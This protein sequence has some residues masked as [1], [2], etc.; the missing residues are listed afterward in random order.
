MKHDH[1]FP[2]PYAFPLLAFFFVAAGSAFSQTT[3][4]IGDLT[5]TG[6][7]KS[8]TS[9]S[10]GGTEL[11][12]GGMVISKGTYS[13]AP[14]LASSDQ[15]AGTRMLWYPGKAAFRVGAVSG[16][17]W[18][19]VN[20]GTY[21]TAFG[22]AST[23]SGS[24]S[25]SAGMYPQASG[26]ASIAMGY[27]PVAT[28][29]YSTAIGFSTHASG[30]GSTAFGYGAIASGPNSTAMGV[31]TVASGDCSTAMGGFSIASGEQATAMGC[32]SIASGLYS[33]SMGICTSA[34]SYGSL[35]VGSYNLGGGD[36]NTWIPTDPLFEIGNANPEVT[37]VRSNAL[38]VYKNGNMDV[39]GVVTSA[40]GGD[41]PMF[42]GN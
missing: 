40:P 35:A 34:E 1:N 29:S 22:L 39:Q 38:T 18:N 23:A 16:N 8:G 6:G 24:Y 42:T 32:F 21:S 13:G 37:E 7:V 11:R 41:I 10:A 30:Y 27:Q 26:V 12:L 9:D 25:M 2:S 31:S 20:I 3:P 14:T 36:P 4:I 17:Q 15:G 5:V 19:E 33:T 28:G